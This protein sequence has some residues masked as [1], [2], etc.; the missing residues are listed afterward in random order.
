M[1]ALGEARQR[2]ERAE[3]D[4]AE[5]RAAQGRWVQE[6]ASKEASDAEQ[7]LH[8]APVPYSSCKVQLVFNYTVCSD[9]GGFAIHIYERSQTTPAGGRFLLCRCQ[10]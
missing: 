4:V 6:L 2:A 10:C 8:R 3:R 7:V 1:Q 5:L 9:P